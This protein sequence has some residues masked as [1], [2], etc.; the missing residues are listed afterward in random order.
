MD[1]VP[2]PIVA[3]DFDER[4]VSLSPKGRFLLYESDETGQ[5]EVWVQPFP[6]MDRK[7]RVST[8]GGVMPLW[9]RR[10]GE[11]FFIDRE[12]RMI[13]ASVQTDPAFQVTDYTAL[14]SLPEDI[15]FQQL[16]W[17]TL[18]D[19]APDDDRFLM[20]RVLDR[21]EADFELGMVQNWLAGREDG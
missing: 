4:A 14:F 11:I 8:D 19:V 17:Y 13:A 16:E 6:N 5:T 18:Y 7:V 2:S 12:D 9:S 10:G 21:G 3:T 1:S 20:M 15:L